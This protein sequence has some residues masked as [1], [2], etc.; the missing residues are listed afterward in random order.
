MGTT[1]GVLRDNDVLASIKGCGSFDLHRVVIAISDHTVALC[2]L[3][4]A[5]TLAPGHWKVR[6]WRS[7]SHEGYFSFLE[8]LHHP[9]FTMTHCLTEKKGGKMFS[10]LV[11]VAAPYRTCH[12]GDGV[13]SG[14][15]HGQYGGVFLLSLIFVDSR[16]M[17]FSCGFIFTDLFLF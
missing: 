8:L 17:T 4:F 10:N 12:H 5:N 6:A 2:I 15:V 7:R 3:Q 9:G 1:Q 13:T 11:N 16:L 14:S